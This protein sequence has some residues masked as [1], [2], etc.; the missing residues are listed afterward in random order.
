MHERVICLMRRLSL[1]KA[2]C[3]ETKRD[4]FNESQ[5]EMGFQYANDCRQRRCQYHI[6]QF[7]REREGEWYT[8]W[9]QN[10]STKVK[11]HVQEPVLTEGKDRTTT[12]SAERSDR[13]IVE[14]GGRNYYAISK[15]DIRLTRIKPTSNI[16]W[17]VGG[18]WSWQK[19]DRLNYDR[20]HQRR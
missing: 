18:R 2:I 9:S 16:A 1:M 19:Y 4:A 14:R 17:H 5:N 12:P 3:W 8:C 6:H 10:D 7:R 11:R 15:A 13:R 20:L